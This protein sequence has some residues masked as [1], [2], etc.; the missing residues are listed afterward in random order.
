ML[1]TG[2]GCYILKEKDR[3]I[4][5]QK[6][7]ENFSFFMSIVSILYWTFK[8]EKFYDAKWNHQIQL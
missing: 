3:G 5:E 6:T 1:D 4:Y 8:P 2:G 7:S